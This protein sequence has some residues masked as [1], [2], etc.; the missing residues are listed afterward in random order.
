MKGQPQLHPCIRTHIQIQAHQ[1]RREDW[2]MFARQ[3]H[4]TMHTYTTTS[5][6]HIHN[7]AQ[8]FSESCPSK[9][10]YVYPHI[11]G[12]KRYILHMCNNIH[13]YTYKML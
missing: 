5:A 9:V 7:H 6:Q 8:L 11:Q 2:Q 4:P 10:I 13:I 3:T 1:E 12:D